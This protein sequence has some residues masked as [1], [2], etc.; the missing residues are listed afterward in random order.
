LTLYANG[1]L[2]ARLQDGDFQTGQVGLRAS[3][4]AGLDVRFDN[5]VVRQAQ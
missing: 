5:F 2:L 1:Q 4:A 3:L